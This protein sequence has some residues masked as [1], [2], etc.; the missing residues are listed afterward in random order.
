MFVVCGPHERHAGLL[1]RLVGDVAQCVLR[2]LATLRR[3]ASEV[4]GIC[5]WSWSERMQLL[6]RI[7]EMLLLAG[8]AGRLFP[9]TIIYNEG[10]LL[11]L[12]LDWFSRQSQSDH[13][14][15]FE[16]DARWF[17]EALLPSQFS[18][19]VRGDRLAE[20]WTHADGVVGHVTIGDRALAN[21]ALRP[22]AT[23]F[24]VTEAKIF[25]PLSIRVTNAPDYDQAARNV[26]CI[27]EILRQ[28]NRKPD[29][30]SSLGFFVIAPAEQIALKIFNSQMS[31]DSIEKKVR[32]RISQYTSP[33]RERK[34][35]WLQNWFLPTLHQAKVDCLSWEQLTADIQA[36]DSDF[37]LAFADFYSDCL[38]YNRI[39]EPE[40]TSRQ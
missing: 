24:V 6:E 3:A 14:L 2:L 30:F 12:V 23:Q 29:Q 15:D 31:K 36:R 18:A 10:W 28:A 21:T 34:D 38:R 19:R 40:L 37:A 32:A 1:V 17:S 33:D 16:A 27:A 8:T 35:D 9:A 11:R 25:S 22:G 5:G 7:R 26:A 13:L 39:Q 4:G 20:G